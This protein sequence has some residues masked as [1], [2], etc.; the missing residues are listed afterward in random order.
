MRLCV[1]ELTLVSVVFLLFPRVRRP[2]LHQVLPRGSRLPHT[3]EC[4][5]TAVNLGVAYGLKRG[6]EPIC[7]GSEKGRPLL[8]RHLAG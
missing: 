4:G 2:H 1:L 6:H 7:G 5:C 3:M 8:G